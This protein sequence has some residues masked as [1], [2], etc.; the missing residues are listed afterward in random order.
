MGEDPAQPRRYKKKKKETPGEGPPDSPTNDPT[1]KYETQPR[2][3]T[4]TGGTLHL[5]QLE[6]LNWLRFSWAQ[7]TDTILADEMGLGKTIQ[8]IVFL[9]SLYKEVGEGAPARHGVGRGGTSAGLGGT[10]VGLGA[11]TWSLGAPKRVWGHLRGHWGHPSGP[12]GT[13]MVIGVTHVVTGGT[14]M[15]LGSLT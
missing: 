7:S 8:T 1:V 12:G 6:G 13:Y 9:Y 4:A 15:G 14:H 11:P 5:Y 2:F 3:I 10:Q